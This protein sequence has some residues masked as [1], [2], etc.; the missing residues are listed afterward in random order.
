MKK[1]S[2][3]PL[4]LVTAIGAVWASTLIF[5]NTTEFPSSPRT[6]GTIGWAL[7]DLFA[8]DG[9]ARDSERLAG[10]Y[11]S[12]YLQNRDCTSEPINRVWVGID[13]DGQ[14]RCGSKTVQLAV[15]GRFTTI[16]GTVR[17]IKNWNPTATLAVIW[18]DLTEWDIL[19]TASDG[20]GTIRFVSDESILRL[21]TSTR[22]E[23]SIGQLS[24]QS[25]AQAILTDGR[26]WGRI[27]SS[28]GVN[29]GGWGLVAW[30]RGTSVSIERPGTTWLYVI[31]VIDS[32]RPLEAATLSAVAGGNTPANIPTSLI[33]GSQVSVSASPTG[34]TTNQLYISPSSPSTTKATLLTSSAWIRDN[35]RADL[36]YLDGL[37]TPRSISEV[38]VTDPTTLADQT[39]LCGIDKKWNTETNT[40]D[41]LNSVL[42]YADKNTFL[43]QWETKPAWWLRKSDLSNYEPADGNMPSDGLIDQQ[44]E[45][46]SYYYPGIF[47]APLQNKT[48]TIE[49][50]GA[51]PI[52]N[53][54]RY[55]LDLGDTEKY[56]IKSGALYA[57][58]PTK[59][60]YDKNIWTISSSMSIQIQT[61]PTQMIIGNLFNQAVTNHLKLPIWTAI[62]KITI[63]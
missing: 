6:P 58:I 10:K 14:A 4:M 50:A 38:A 27:L 62:Q 2:L 42:A 17:V 44:W 15:I 63:K 16:V 60:W 18:E 23:L 47:V 36:I 1:F 22:V 34:S 54:K 61:T 12:G 41:I 26:L 31:S 30:V 32:I 9:T 5:P 39:A 13:A 52:D 21:D 33:A 3:L 55:I 57:I 8:P 25:V 51:L 28:T 40:C 24:G 11:A 7:Y 46:L 49:L 20:T 48:I 35:T 53:I 56:Y 43:Y 37:A 45:Y 59:W 29:L 19:E